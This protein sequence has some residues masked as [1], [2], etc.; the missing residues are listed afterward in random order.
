MYT[1]SFVFSVV[2]LCVGFMGFLYGLT[3]IREIK[4]LQERVA[5]T[6]EMVKEVNRKLYYKA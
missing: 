5:K 3:A 6:E 1:N 4:N 2:G